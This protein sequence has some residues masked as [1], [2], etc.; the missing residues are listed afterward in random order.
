MFSGKNK[1]KLNGVKLLT[2]F[3]IVLTEPLKTLIRHQIKQRITQSLRMYCLYEGRCQVLFS[4]LTV[5]F[6]G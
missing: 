6:Q 2:S 4:K 3:M 5:M 1:T